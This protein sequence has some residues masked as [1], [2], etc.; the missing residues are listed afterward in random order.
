MS[1]GNLTTEAAVAAFAQK[2]S[3]GGSA[4]AVYGGWTA[5]EVAAYG[6]LLI[7]I[8]GLLVQVFYKVRADRREIAEHAARMAVLNSGRDD[9]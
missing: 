9:E 7:A 2:A 1:D 6:G 5:N 4:A 8:V 3:I